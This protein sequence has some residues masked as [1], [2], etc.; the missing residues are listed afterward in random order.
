[1]WW[2][3]RER[4]L[5]REV[6]SHLELEAEDQLENG[7][8]QEQARIAAEKAFGNATLVKEEI[9]AM[10]A[11]TAL[12]RLAQDLRYGFRTMGRNRGFA[13]CG[14]SHA[15]AR[16]RCEHRHLQCAECRGTAPPPGPRSTTARDAAMERQRQVEVGRCEQQ[17]CRMRC[18]PTARRL[19]WMFVQLSGVRVLPVESQFGQRTRRRRRTGRDASAHPR[20]D[21]PHLGAVC[22]RQF[23]PHAGY[24][25]T[26]KTDHRRKR[27][28]GGRRS[29][30]R[31]ERALLGSPFSQRPCGIGE[32]HFYRGK[33]FHGSRSGRQRVHRLGTIGIAGSLGCSARRL[34]VSLRL[35]GDLLCCGLLPTPWRW[36][37]RHERPCAR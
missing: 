24:Y 13:A 16:N 30:G 1:M 14:H 34:A 21:R 11:W 17:L 18:G 19:R 25:R 35:A 33:R 6:R 7:L 23:L 2:R 31:A 5:E 12:D 9:R 4:D 27:R 37:E 22:K 10:S 8:P 26:P 29:S 36:L 15:R 28:S 3:R 32:N 20:R